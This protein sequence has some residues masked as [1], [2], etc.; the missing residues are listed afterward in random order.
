MRR[1]FKEQ[2]SWQQD[3]MV[4]SDGEQQDAPK[5]SDSIETIKTRTVLSSNKSRYKTNASF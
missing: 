4:S 2:K 1:R 3:D 5:A